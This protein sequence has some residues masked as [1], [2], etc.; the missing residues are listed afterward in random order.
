MNKKILLI[1]R[2]SRTEFLEKIRENICSVFHDVDYHW[3]IVF[4]LNRMKMTP[5][6]MSWLSETGKKMKMFYSFS[7]SNDELYGSNLANQV[8]F[9]SQHVDCGWAYLL[10]DDNALCTKLIEAMPYLFEEGEGIVYVPQLRRNH[11]TSEIETH[12]I[13]PNMNADNCV[14][15]VDSAQ[16]F[17]PTELLKSIGGYVD[18]YCI[19]GLT[20]QKIY[21]TYPYIKK[22]YVNSG[23]SYYNYW[24]E[25]I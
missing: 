12:Y 24:T 5:E 4:D 17:I 19:D 13:N 9:D 16:F 20:I 18:G 25:I 15:W 6:L 23:C 22:V 1:T 8:L 2:C 10:D 7:G 21:Q 14:G 11:E 3:H